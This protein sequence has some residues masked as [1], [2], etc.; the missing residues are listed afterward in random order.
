MNNYYLK[1]IIRLLFWLNIIIFSS[2]SYADDKVLETEKTLL[3]LQ[4]EI[5][6]LDKNIKK[7]TATKNNL[8]NE[9]K[10]KERKISKTKKE[11]YKINK[12]FKSNKKKIK[13]L[14][15][16]LT[17]LKKDIKVKKKSLSSRLYQ[18]YTKGNPGYL[19]MFLDGVN[20]SQISR[21]SYYIGYY[22]QYQ[23]ANIESIKK[24][25]KDINKT[26]NAT[27][28]ALKKVASLKKQKEK[29]AKKLQKQ[30]KEK[31]KVIKKIKKK[32]NSQKK[33]K[34]KLIQNE[35]KLN[36]IVSE[37][38]KKIKAESKKKIVE[39]KIRPDKKLIPDVKFDGINFTKLKGKLK[40]PVKGKIIQKFNSKRK[41]T[42][43]RWKGLFI[44]SKEGNEVYSIATGKIVFSDWLDGYGNLIII[45]HG[46]GYMSLYGNNQALIKQ[47][48]EVIKGGSTIAIVGNS[49][50]NSTNGLYYQLRKNSKPFNPLK[51]TKL[52]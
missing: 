15:A 2:F 37:L 42:G 52:K 23:N 10:K 3:K 44:K 13:K 47:K 30:K 20:P 11:L 12:K 48:G 16:E 5:N 40:L 35:K 19:Q 41:D 27:N 14:N 4:K 26:K 6:Q 1:N 32:L 49:G 21:E 33:K 9:L 7:N 18:A 34:K 39:K 31:T 50:G 17:K 36:A 22:S 45:D 24:A 38:I 28:K 25:Y 8:S 43:T 46:K 29:N 51:W